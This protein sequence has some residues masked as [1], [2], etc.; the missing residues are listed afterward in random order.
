MTVDFGIQ[1][2]NLSAMSQTPETAMSCT[3][4]I[5]HQGKTPLQCLTQ[6]SLKCLYI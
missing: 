5:C 1:I 6:V 2:Q 4:N 3:I